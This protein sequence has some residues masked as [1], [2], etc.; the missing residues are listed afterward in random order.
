[1][2]K[3]F[4]QKLLEAQ[5]SISAITKSK[6]NPFFKSK[7]AD[8]NA[9]LSEV[10]PKL[11]EAGLVLTQP[12]VILDGRN[13]LETIIADSESAEYIKSSLILPEI[14]DVQKFGGAITYF[15]R[16][17]IQSLLGLEAEDDDGNSVVGNKVEK[18]KV[19]NKGVN[20]EVGEPFG[21]SLTGLN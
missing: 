20:A 16:Y 8:I 13:V 12:T 5:K 1:M 7:Y 18:P 11:N 4:N 10:K 15:R 14:A 3:T 17:E 19:S 2:T 9:Y 21:E 6:D